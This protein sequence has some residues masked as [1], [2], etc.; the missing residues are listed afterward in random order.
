M[1]VALARISSL[2]GRVTTDFLRMALFVEESILHTPELQ[3]TEV[4][5]DAVSRNDV[6]YWKGHPNSDHFYLETHTFRMTISSKTGRRT[7]F[8]IRA[9]NNRLIRL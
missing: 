2:E 4:V 7:E 3:T 6:Y 5:N 8:Q 9:L 1:V